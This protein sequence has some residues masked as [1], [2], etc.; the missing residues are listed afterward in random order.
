MSAL[1]RI[2]SV[3]LALVSLPAQ[4]QSLKQVAVSLQT[5]TASPG[6]ELA[7]ILL[8]QVDAAG[9]AH[10]GVSGC[11]RF[12][13]AG[14]RCLDRLE[15]ADA[16]RVASLSKLVTAIGAMRLVETGVLDLDRDVSDYLGFTL[17]NPAYPDTVISLRMLLSHT[18]SLRDTALY[19][20]AYP[21]T[22]QQ[23]MAAHDWFDAGHLPGRYFTYCNLGYGIVAT[24]MEAATRT[25]F[26]TL[27][28]Q[29]VFEP[30]GVD[31]AYNWSGFNT[32]KAAALYRWQDDRW[33][34]TIDDFGGKRA[35]ATVMVGDGRGP[36]P[37]D[38]RPG[39][40]GTLFS[41]QGGLRITL[42]GLGRIARTLLADGAPL[43]KPASL[44]AMMTPAWRFDGGNG[45]TEGGFYTG[46]GLGMQ[47]MDDG[48]AG[49][50]AEAYGLRGGLVVDRA[51]GIAG[52]YLITG[53]RR[54]PSEDPSEMPGL[55][56]PEARALGALLKAERGSR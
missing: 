7:G 18:S 48:K 45:D 13:A 9:K 24:V 20:M 44:K 21:G 2:F 38:Y 5:A 12:D 35:V 14:V 43:L 17:R 22:L 8:W 40:N 3:L 1:S 31:A 39:S 33:V 55:A 46:F 27:M 56:W 41:P 28:R 11:A 15:A 54:D 23:L 6:R 34:A 26:D 32:G 25:R 36:V 51:R 52:V 50:F 53:F 30:L 16:L 49:H 47:L 42:D 29:L 10:T 19:A 4:A 37:H